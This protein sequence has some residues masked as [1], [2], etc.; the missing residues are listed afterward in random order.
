MRFFK[1]KRSAPRKSR[2]TKRAVGRRGSSVSVGVKKYVKKMIHTQ[3]ENKSVQINGGP[4]SFGNVLESPDFNAY[5]MLPLATY[6]TI[7]QGSGAGN[8]VGNII[9]TRKVMLN[10]VLYPLPYDAGTNATPQPSEVRLML[11]YVKNTPSFAPIAGDINQLF[12]AGSTS[13]A[14]VGTLKDLISVYNNDYWAIKKSW[15]HK[16]G[17]ASSTGTGGNA[18]QE[19]YANNDFKYNIVRKLNITKHCPSTCVFNDTSGTTNTKNL[20]FMFYAVA[21]NGL[22]YSNIALP[23]RIDFWIDYVYEDA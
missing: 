4:V 22:S 7:N 15:T 10:Y 14:P 1:K 8:R 13:Q 19:F 18:G 6:W 2:T 9:K 11:G 17:Y 20:F 16:L 21:A 23:C 5:P 3:I 12:N